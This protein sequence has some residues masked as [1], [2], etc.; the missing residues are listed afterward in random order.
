MKKQQCKWDYKGQFSKDEVLI[1]QELANQ[2]SHM[3]PYII[4]KVRINL[5]P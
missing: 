1:Y 2:V 3:V 5:Q 4:C